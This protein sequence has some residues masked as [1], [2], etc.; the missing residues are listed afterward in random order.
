MLCAYARK[1]FHDARAQGTRWKEPD[2]ACREACHKEI[3]DCRRRT[4]IE[5][6]ILR[7]IA[8]DGTYAPIIRIDEA[9]TARMR[10]FTEDG[11]Q[12][13]T[14]TRAVC[15]D[16]GGQ[17][18]AV[19]VQADMRKDFERPKGDAEVLDFSAAEMCTALRCTSVMKNMPEHNDPLF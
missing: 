5:A 7:H 1:I 9:Q 10:H 3:H 18:P 14:L 4:Q 13:R 8:N 12:E 11:T 17:L 16:D 15:P 19:N 6:Q 2:R